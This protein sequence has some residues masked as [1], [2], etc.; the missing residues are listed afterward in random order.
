M[1]KETARQKKIGELIRLSFY[2]NRLHRVLMEEII[3]GS[4]V[5][6]SQHHMLATVAQA[7]SVCQRDIARKLEISSAAVAVTL[8]KLEEA[9]LITRTQSYDDARMNQITVTEKGTALLKTTKQALD[10]LDEEFFNGI[11]DEE[12]DTLVSVM[13]KVNDN[14]GVK[15]DQIEQRK[16]EEKKKKRRAEKLARKAQQEQ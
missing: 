1:K 12:L 14:A 2:T 8:S 9:G 7:K 16:K 10:G 5:H 13:R 4:G 15:A 11:T 3:D 6:V